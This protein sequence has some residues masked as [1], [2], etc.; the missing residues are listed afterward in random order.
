MQQSYRVFRKF[1]CF[2]SLSGCPRV[3]RLDTV[4]AIYLPNRW[5]V[6]LHIHVNDTCSDKILRSS[7][8]C[9]PSAAPVYL[10]Y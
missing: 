8:L 9:V 7:F 4:E 5:N 6:S 2:L 1:L 10:T 3:A